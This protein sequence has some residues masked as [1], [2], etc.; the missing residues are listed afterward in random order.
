MHLREHVPLLGHVQKANYSYNAIFG[1]LRRD[2]VISEL[3]YRGAQWL[4]GRMLD[5]RPRGCR[6]KPY[7]CHCVVSLSKTH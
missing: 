3:C 2:H 6:Y 1:I 5:P 4:S 7:R